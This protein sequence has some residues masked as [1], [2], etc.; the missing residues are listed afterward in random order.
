[1]STPS[2]NQATANDLRRAGLD[3]DR[4]GT[5]NVGDPVGNC[6]P[7]KTWVAI[8]LVDDEGNPIAGQQYRLLLPDGSPKEGKLDD[9]GE[10]WVENIDAGKCEVSFSQL[11]KLKL[12]LP[13]AQ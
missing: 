5:G 6:A 13:S 3:A 11:E 2:P 10:V 9:S 8:R 12:P 4:L 7:T 1:M